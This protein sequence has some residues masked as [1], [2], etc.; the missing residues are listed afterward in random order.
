[1]LFTQQNSFLLL[2]EF[3]NGMYNG[4]GVYTRCDGM[5]FEGGFKNGNPY[6][7]GLVTFSNGTNGEPRQEGYFEGT[8]LVRREPVTEYIKKAR[9]CRERARATVL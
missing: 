8:K 1:M 4:F 6:G 7:P 3:T 2:G 5:M 9:A